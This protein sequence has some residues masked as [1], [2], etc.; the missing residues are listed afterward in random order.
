MILQG[1]IFKIR[2]KNTELSFSNHIMKGKNL[3]V[4]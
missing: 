4:N 1:K 3:H 2:L